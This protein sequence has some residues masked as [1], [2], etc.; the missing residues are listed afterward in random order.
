MHNEKKEDFGTEIYSN[1]SI[2]CHRFAIDTLKHS[3][4]S[5]PHSIAVLH[6]QNLRK[7]LTLQ[8]IRHLLGVPDDITVQYT[9]MNDKASV[10]H[11]LLTFLRSLEANETVKQ[12]IAAITTL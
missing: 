2:N 4:L 12:V 1:Y 5:V 6:R 8:E 7:H 10:K 11:L 9:D 3:E